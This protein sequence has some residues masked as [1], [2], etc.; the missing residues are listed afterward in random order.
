MA[1]TD[2]G[3]NRTWMY[4]A[5][6]APMKNV[7]KLLVAYRPKEAFASLFELATGPLRQP[8]FNGQVNRAKFF[9]SNRTV[10]LAML[11]VLTDQDPAAYNLT[12]VTR[13]QGNW[14]F[15]S[16]LDEDKAIGKLR[17]WWALHPEYAAAT[18]APAS[19]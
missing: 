9:W 6:S 13:P 3:Q 1:E 11:V 4:G 17:Q 2:A 14:A 15:A 18:T 19:Q 7:Y 12:Q 5:T 8:V 16:Q 10:P